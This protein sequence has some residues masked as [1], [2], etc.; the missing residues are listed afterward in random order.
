MDI[1]ANPNSHETWRSGEAYPKTGGTD[2]HVVCDAGTNRNRG[3]Y[4][5]AVSAADRFQQSS[6]LFYPQ[7]SGEKEIPG[8]MAY[9]GQKVVSRLCVFDRRRCG[10]SNRRPAKGPRSDEAFGYR[11]RDHSTDPGRN[12]APPAAWKR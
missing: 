4:L 6:A 12:I 2:S 10:E 7:I 3:K 9:P 11:R 1:M 8:K 5:S